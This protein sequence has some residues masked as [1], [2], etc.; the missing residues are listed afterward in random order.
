[1]THPAASLPRPEISTT[2]GPQIGEVCLHPSRPP[3][4]DRAAFLIPAQSPRANQPPMNTELI[5]ALAPQL[6]SLIHPGDGDTPPYPL[7]LPTFQTA[8]L[9]SGMAEELAEQLGIPNAD[10]S[11]MFLEA[12]FHQIGAAGYD[13]VP[14]TAHA[15]LQVAAAANEHKRNA[16]KHFHGKCGAPLFRAMVTDFNTDQPRINC[17]V[18]TALGNMNPDCA[19]GHKAAA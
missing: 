5:A 17:A 2:V 19:S 16:V 4:W 6:A 13:I 10:I 15:E 3:L 8:T 14:K 12:L 1:M 11:T 9:P 18:I 7:C